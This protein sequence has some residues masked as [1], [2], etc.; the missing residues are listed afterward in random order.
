MISRTGVAAAIFAT[1]FLAMV[2]YLVS[3]AGQRARDQVR[4]ERARVESI[5]EA[6]GRRNE[7]ESLSDDDLLSRLGR[8]I[9]PDGGP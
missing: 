6:E 1:V 3:A 8:W 7:I 2:S 5:K 4:A 9:L